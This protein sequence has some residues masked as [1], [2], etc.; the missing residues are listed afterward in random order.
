[1]YVIGNFIVGYI[2]ESGGGAG[3][4]FNRSNQFG[5]SLLAHVPE[6]RTGV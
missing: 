2:A 3:N 5:K 1:M 6:C 4:L